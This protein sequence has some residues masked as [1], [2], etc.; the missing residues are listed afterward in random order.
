MSKMMIAWMISTTS[1]VTSDERS[2]IC[3]PVR[4]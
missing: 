1:R 4:R 2:M 3:A